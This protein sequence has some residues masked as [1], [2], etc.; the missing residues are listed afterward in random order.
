MPV[1]Q[2]IATLA[3]VFT[4]IG[5]RPVAAQIDYRNLDDHRPVRTEDAY[6]IERYAFELVAPYEY[7]NGRAGEQLHVVAPELSYGAFANTQ[8]GL[9]LPLAALHTTAGTDWGFAGPRLFG[10]YNFNTEGPALPAL[11]LRADLALPT[12]DLGPDA[13]QLT[14]KALATRSWGRTRLHLN[15]AG[16]L[17]RAAGRAAVDAEPRWALSLAADQTFYRQ[18]VLLIGE[19]GVLEA[20]SEAP[21]DVSAALGIRYQ[22]TPTLVLD[23]G[24]SRRLTA[25]AGPDLGLT[26]GLTHAFAFAGW[27]PGA[28]R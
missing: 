17:G 1:V 3:I 8:V 20:A 6:P 10:L 18:S 15:A 5:L 14:L 28:S 4:I 23:A 12:G 21:T 19:L 25:R 26:L 27:L 16:T 24:V 22:L 9:R 11:A 13:T 2:R 7:E